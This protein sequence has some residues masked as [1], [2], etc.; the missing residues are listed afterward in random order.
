MAGQLAHAV[1]L[2][3]GVYGYGLDRSINKAGFAAGSTI[4]HVTTLANTG[5]GSLREA[6]GTTTTN[7][8]VVVFDVAGVIDLTESLIVRNSNI[9]IAGQTAPPPGIALHGAQLHVKASNVLVQHIAVRAGDRWGDPTNINQTPSRD[10]VT[11]DPGSQLETA[12]TSNVV[13]DHCSFSWALDETASLWNKYDNITFHKCIFAEPLH[14]GI[15]LDE[16]TLD[17]DLSTSGFQNFPVQPEKTGF[18]LDKS[19]GASRSTQSHGSAVEDAYELITADASTTQQWVEYKLPLKYPASQRNEEHIVIHYVKRSDGAQF[20]VRVSLPNGTTILD[21]GADTI[22]TYEGGT[23]E[24]F[25]NDGS[26]TYVGMRDTTTIDGFSIPADT[27]YLRVRFIVDVGGR[28]P[29]ST[30][31]KLGI[32]QISLSQNHA[33]GP[34]WGTGK[35]GGFEA[36]AKVAMIGCVIAHIQARGVWSVAKQFYY[37]NNVMYNRRKQQMMFAKSGTG[38]ADQVIKAA[39]IGNTIIEGADWTEQYE[40]ITNPQNVTMP[41]GSSIYV[42]DLAWNQGLPNIALDLWD[43]SEPKIDGP[44]D[45]TTNPLLPYTAGLNGFTPLSA[46]AALTDALDTAGTRPAARDTVDTRIINDIRN[47]TDPNMQRS[48]RLGRLKNSVEDAGGWPTYATPTPVVWDEPDFPFTV[49]ASGYTNIEEELH[50][51]AAA[52]EGTLDPSA[53][54]LDNFEDNNANGWT[55]SGT[56]SWA[57]AQVGTAGMPDHNKV[58]AQTNTTGDARSTLDGTN[59]TTQVI[60]AD[61]TPTSFNGTDRWIGVMGRFSDDSNFYYLILRD[62]DKIDLKKVVNGSVSSLL[63][64]TPTY[65]VTTNTTYRLRLSL[66][67]TSLSGTVSTWNPTTNTWTN[68]T[69]VNATDSSLSS[70]R[71]G[72]AMFK[73]AARVNNVLATPNIA[74]TT[75][76]GDAFD[77]GSA[78]DWTTV[79]L[80]GGSANWSVVS[81]GTSNVYRQSNSTTTAATY[82][83]AGNSTWTDQVLEVDAKA[84]TFGTS[85]QFFGVVSRFTDTSNYYYFILRANNTVELKKYVAGVQS[86]LDTAQFTVSTTPTYDL[87]LEALGPTLNAYVDGRLV[88][89]AQDTSLPAGKIG[90]KLLNTAAEFDNVLVSQP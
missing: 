39:V 24:T 52:L 62:S 72:V 1:Q 35:S 19:S 20:R 18:F 38:Y 47:S 77:S 46:A 14:V 15:H 81:N 71:A 4:V 80:S 89:E 86:T 2:L 41:T 13:F 73:A 7:P 37:A 88:L 68:S 29:S 44:I 48:A 78:D 75:P 8:K 26:Q 66:N 74:P 64:S 5:T 33:M 17:N 90:L 87:K 61:I 11:I 6:V 28:N 45:T 34:L 79:T 65:T 53:P 27:Q 84:N 54:I 85:S 21:P 31:W 57:I 16:S 32:D 40:P 23:L 67:G 49:N 56:P 9:T 82:A 69:P 25:S 12:V 3:P 51:L 55:P 59:W 83:H 58:Y 70:G 50:S 42:N 63:S 60:Q 36:G 43:H 30:G 22:D 10:A 76:F